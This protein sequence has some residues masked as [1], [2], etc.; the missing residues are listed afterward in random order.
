MALSVFN[1]YT[2]KKELFVPRTRNLV[3]IYTCGLTVYD[4]MHIGHARTYIF[5]DIFRRYLRFC[6]YEVICVINYTDIEDKI[7]ERA[8]ARGVDFR[9]FADEFIDAFDEDSDKLGIMPYSVQCRASDYIPEMV[10]MV[11]SLIEN[12]YAYEVDGDVFFDVHAFKPYGRL[13]GQ[14]LEDLE[15]GARVEVD[16]RKRHPADFALWKASKPGEPVWESPWGEGRPGWHIECSVM[17]SHFLGDRLDVHGGAVDNMFPHHE[18]EIAQS[19]AHFG[20]PPDTDER[21]CRYWMHPEHLLVEGEKMS[22]SVG[23]FI[24]VSEIL[25]DTEPNALRLYFLGNHYRTQMN[26]TREGLSGAASALERIMNFIET[27][28]QRLVAVEEV[29]VKDGDSHPLTELAL[30]MREKFIVAMDDDVNCTAALASI[31][32]FIK[33]ANQAGWESCENPSDIAPALWILDELLLVLGLES[34]EM[35]A[36]EGVERL[37]SGLLDLIISLRDSARSRKDFETS[38]AI[39][40][41]LQSL[42][43]VLEDTP[44]GTRWKRKG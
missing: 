21:W 2:R 37:E 39:R 29:A 1:T 10:E 8:K 31:F 19:E 13:S 30:D 36:P 4:R 44:G 43:I 34:G 35:E 25:E 7:F 26:F 14:N 17:S 41:G 20:I 42:G 38:D 6:D 33:A 40:N 24:T 18:N 3:R 32:D 15:A 16:E 5:W 23:N 11:K 28:S 22:K 9:E 12:G 27:G